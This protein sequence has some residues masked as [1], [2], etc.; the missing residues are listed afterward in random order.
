MR[1]Q[2]RAGYRQRTSNRARPGCGSALGS[3]RRTR[4]LARWQNDEDEMIRSYNRAGDP[5]EACKLWDAI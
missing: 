2:D 4:L 3:D 1:I 5:A